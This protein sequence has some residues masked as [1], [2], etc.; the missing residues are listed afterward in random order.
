M[1]YRRKL[2][3]IA[4][5]LLGASSGAKKTHIMYQANLSYRLLTK[6]LEVV[7][8][9]Y[10][11]SFERKQRRYVLTSKGQQFLEVYK[12]YAKGNRVVENRLNDVDGK[13][14]RLEALCSRG[15]CGAA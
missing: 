3:I 11:L 6:Y 9:A 2:D 4:D 8:K 10:L 7:R 1:T 5:M 14:K 12:E 13:R 15:N